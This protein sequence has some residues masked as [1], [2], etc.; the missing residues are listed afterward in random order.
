MTATTTW[1]DEP[2]A[3]DMEFNPHRLQLSGLD[4]DP[5]TQADFAP[6]LEA[7]VRTIPSQLV[8]FEVEVWQ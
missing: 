6:E 4:G 1:L 5:L 2:Q 7:D 8:S 3:P